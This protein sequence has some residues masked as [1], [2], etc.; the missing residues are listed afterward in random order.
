MKQELENVLFCSSCG[1]HLLQLQSVFKEFNVAKCYF[2]SELAKDSEEVC[3]RYRFRRS[4]LIKRVGSSSRAMAFKKF[5]IKLS[6]VFKYLHAHRFDVEYWRNCIGSAGSNLFCF[7]AKDNFCG[8]YSEN[9]G[10]NIYSQNFLLYL[11]SI[12]CSG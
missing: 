8:N 5:F 7:K 3:S 9:S 1:G 6:K 4:I 12:F 2:I 11:R 10:F